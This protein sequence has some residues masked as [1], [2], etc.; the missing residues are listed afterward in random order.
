MTKQIALLR[1][2]NVSGK[3]KIRMV[4]LRGMFETLGFRNVKTYVQSGNVIFESAETDHTIL[5]SQIETAITNKFGDE[6]P[7]FLRDVNQFIGVANSNPF[8][9]NDAR[10][11][12]KFYVTFLYR[13]PHRTT[14]QQVTL[15]NNEPAEFAIG[16]REIYLYCPNGYGKTKLT[17]TYFEKKLGIPATTRNWKTVNSLFS[18]AQEST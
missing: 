14:L 17:N 16:I 2:I 18:M 5:T 9:Q 1:G 10:D 8:S 4:D 13:L 6:V 15:P 11:P 12:A 3:K 7:V